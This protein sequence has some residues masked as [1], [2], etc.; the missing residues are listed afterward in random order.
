MAKKASKSSYRRPSQ[1]R[2]T[3]RP[4]PSAAPTPR[5]PLSQRILRWVTTSNVVLVVGLIVVV[6]ILVLMY[7]RLTAPVPEAA[8][9]PAASPGMA[10]ALSDLAGGGLTLG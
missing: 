9:P 5:R 4:H 8:L 6:V 2:A 7:F 10:L 3:K 1:A